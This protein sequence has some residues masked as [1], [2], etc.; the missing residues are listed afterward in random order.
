M[1]VVSLDPPAIDSGAARL[2]GAWQLAHQNP[3]FGGFSALV[4][5][6]GQ[7]LLAGSDRGK[8]LEIALSGNSPV[9]GRL[10]PLPE[11]IPPRGSDDLEAMSADARRGCLWFAF[12]HGNTIAR[13]CRGE[14]MR[15]VRPAPMRR[16][17]GNGGP[18]TMVR[19]R[20]GRFVVIAESARGDDGLF[21][22]LVFAGDPLSSTKVERFTL[23]A[24]PGYRPVDAA[25]LPPAPNGA[26]GDVLILLRRLEGRFPPRFSSALMLARLD[27]LAAALRGGGTWRGGVALRL[28]GEL[29][30][31]YEGLAVEP[32]D[33]AP[34]LL[35]LV[36]DDNFSI[37]QRSLLLAFEWRGLPG[38]ERAKAASATD[39]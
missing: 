21:D 39:E 6:D 2:I 35:F 8:L 25:Q 1:A 9:D 13:R 27:S 26:G 30:E 3:H 18:E 20:D 5:L 15:A 36:S 17:P 29:A 7:R 4:A 33:R 12:E 11:S 32:R 16:W 19:L 24:P 23:A 28:D 38:S 37:F 14:R 31:N 10:Q 22:G 34:P